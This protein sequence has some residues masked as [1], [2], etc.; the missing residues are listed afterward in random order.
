[1]SSLRQ[2]IKFNLKVGF[3]LASG[4]RMVLNQRSIRCK[5]CDFFATTKTEV[6]HHFNA[7]H[8]DTTKED[9]RM[10]RIIEC[11]GCRRFTA[12]DHRRMAMHKRICYR[13]FPTSDQNPCQSFLCQFCN[14]RTLYKGKFN[15]HMTNR[16]N[17]NDP[18]D[19]KVIDKIPEKNIVKERNHPSNP[20][21]LTGDPNPKE[22]VVKPHPEVL[23][24]NL[25]EGKVESGDM[26]G[27][28]QCSFET[29]N[30]E[31]FDSH[32][33]EKHSK[34][35]MKTLLRASNQKLRSE[36]TTLKIKVDFN[37]FPQWQTLPTKRLV[38]P[39]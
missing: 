14:F 37:K 30:P 34:I 39:R 28:L 36:K 13:S 9:R 16:H 15:T 31:L 12:P 19:N 29:H 8:G 11:T 17:Q 38:Y 4:S 22:K 1:M 23:S 25:R 35:S 32:W 5:R 24:N 27:C 10:V 2:P 18:T 6:V 26:L 21:V 20:N 3:F 33:I 7:Y